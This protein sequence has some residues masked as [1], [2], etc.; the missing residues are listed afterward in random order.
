MLLIAPT[1]GSDIVVLELMV[2]LLPET[3]Q[4]MAEGR[5]QVD[6]LTSNS[7]GNDITM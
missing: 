2:T 6:P 4:V 3:L 1:R 7:L 5:E